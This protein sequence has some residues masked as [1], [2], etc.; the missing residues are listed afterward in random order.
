MNTEEK[1]T[2]Q[3]LVMNLDRDKKLAIHFSEM[4]VLPH[5]MRNAAKSL[6]DKIA[7]VEIIVNDQTIPDREKA[8]L[9]Q[10]KVKDILHQHAMF[11]ETVKAGGYT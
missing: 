1:L 6:A 11:M 10:G 4:A 5:Y 3:K 8:K 9:L 2:Y 7:E